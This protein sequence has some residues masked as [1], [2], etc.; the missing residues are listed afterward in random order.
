MENF[1]ADA[2]QGAFSA[3]VAAY[4]LVRMES[5]LDGLTNAIVRL[6]A[7]IDVMA[8]RDGDERKEVSA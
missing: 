6:N 3:A 1:S 7:A 5:R 4:L 8:R 2:I